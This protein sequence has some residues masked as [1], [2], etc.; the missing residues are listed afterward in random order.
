MEC[1][2][3][4]CSRGSHLLYSLS[5]RKSSGWVCFLGEGEGKVFI[6]YFSVLIMCSDM[7]RG[8]VSF[9]GDIFSCITVLVWKLAGEIEQQMSQ[10]LVEVV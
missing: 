8:F 6:V 10:Q 2:Q 9:E 5:L 3:V 4:C 1:S 7:G